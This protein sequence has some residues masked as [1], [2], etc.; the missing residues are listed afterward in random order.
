MIG[1]VITPTTQDKTL[2]CSQ[3]YCKI[4]WE[5][6]ERIWDS[7]C[8]NSS[9][10]RSANFTIQIENANKILSEVRQFRKESNKLYG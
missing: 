3:R 10:K 7:E 1:K 4:S 9:L 5:I 8:K 6:T 2:V